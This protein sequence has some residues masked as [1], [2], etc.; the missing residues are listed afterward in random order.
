MFGPRTV[1]LFFKEVN[2][3]PFSNYNN[4]YEY[5]SEKYFGI[6][7][8][9]WLHLKNINSLCQKLDILLTFKICQ[10]AVQPKKN[11]RYKHLLRLQR[12][13]ISLLAII[14]LFPIDRDHLVWHFYYAMAA[15]SLGQI[16]IV[17]TNKYLFLLEI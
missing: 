8:R 13:T 12:N 11:V 15:S 9:F 5:Y 6:R 3:E 14:L 2:A 7:K 17:F 16:V 1:L 4:N 10:T